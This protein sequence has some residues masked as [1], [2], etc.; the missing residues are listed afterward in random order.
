MNSTSSSR[1]YLK[2]R[3]K[4]FRDKERPLDYGRNLAPNERRTKF[5]SVLTIEPSPS[6]DLM[7]AV[8]GNRKDYELDIVLLS[9]KDGSPIRNLTPG[10]DKDR[11]FEYIAV[12]GLALE[13]GAVD[14]VVAARR[15]PRLLRP[16][17]EAALA[18]DPERRDRQDRTAHPDQGPGRR[19]SRP[20]SR[21][22]ASPW[23]SPRSQN[24]IGDIYKLD[25]A[26]GE[27]TNLTK[28]DFADYAPT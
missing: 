21:P 10:F 12:P 25:L 9:T 17:R 27:I 6:G 23:C 15:S 18:A 28:D 22:T 14:V 2:D 13:L 19:R 11:G 8:T 26:S 16:H 24:A 3:F 5:S 20:T 4:S 7:A 1:S